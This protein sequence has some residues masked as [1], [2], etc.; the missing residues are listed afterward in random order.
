MQIGQAY[1]SLK[2]AVSVNTSDPPCKDS[3]ARFTPVPQKVLSV[4]CSSLNQISKVCFF[5]L[6]IF[7]CGFSAKVTCAFLVYKKQSR[8]SQKINT[9]LVRKTTAYSTFEIRLRFQG[10]LC[11]SG[12]AIFLLGG[13]LAP[14]H[15]TCGSWL[16]A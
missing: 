6:F 16:S 3:N 2:G 15:C 5:K 14:F 12:N 7:T 9:F 13:S 8:N 11:K 1:L 10:Y 4:Q